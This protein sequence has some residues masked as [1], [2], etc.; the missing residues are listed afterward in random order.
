MTVIRVVG[1]RA[2]INHPL[3]GWVSLYTRDGDQ[4]MKKCKGDSSA[5]QASLEAQFE[6]KRREVEERKKTPAP[7]KEDSNLDS[8][9]PGGKKDRSPSASSRSSSEESAPRP[10]Q[11]ADLLGGRGE[12]PLPAERSCVR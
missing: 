8:W 12:R 9:R 2:Q 10:G 1:R 11:Q 7:Q 5:V 4:I 3:D 6:R